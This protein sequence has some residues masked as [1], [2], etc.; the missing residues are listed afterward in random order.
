MLTRRL[1]AA[2]ALCSAG[3]FVATEVTAAEG[4]VSK[5][6]GVS[7]KILQQMDGPVDGYVTIV[8]EAEIPAGAF[9]A[10][11][12]HPGIESAYLLE[13]GGQLMVKGLANRKLK[14]GDGFQ[15]A[16]VTPHALQN[17][18][19]VTK[20]AGTYVIEKGKPLASPSKPG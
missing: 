15:I 11:H 4:A 2:C 18:N 19:A 3:G 5:S 8:V 12:T 16:A 13:G 7:R 1:F 9:V 17:G 6:P 20:V 14:P 10:W